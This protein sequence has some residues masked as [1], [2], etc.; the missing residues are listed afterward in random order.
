M[1]SRVFGNAPEAVS[2]ARHY[3]VEEL[4]AVPRAIVDEVAVMVSELATNCVR[5]T[6]TEFTV[7]V[8]HDAKQVRVA[9]TDRGAGAPTLKVP[10]ASEPTGRGLRIVRELADS[11]GVDPSSGAPGKTVWFVVQL[12]HAAGP[13]GSQTETSARNIP[14]A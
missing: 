11:F 14:R 2:A 3:V 5:H 6:D 12:D 1:T 7:S 10:D 4:A 8:E 13:R 9:V